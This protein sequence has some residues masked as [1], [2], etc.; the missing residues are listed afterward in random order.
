MAENVNADKTGCRGK[1][2][3]MVHGGKRDRNEHDR[4]ALSH[5]YLAQDREQRNC[6]TIYWN[7]GISLSLTSTLTHSG[8]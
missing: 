2:V 4:N 8:I 5:S 3:S 1:Y 7:R 6:Y